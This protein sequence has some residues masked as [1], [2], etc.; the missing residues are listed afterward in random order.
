MWRFSLVVALGLN[1]FGLSMPILRSLT[2]DWTRDSCIGRWILYHWA[3]RK[4]PKFFFLQHSE[5]KD[6]GIRSHHF[7]ANR[8]GKNGNSERLY[9]GGASKSLQMVT[10]AMKTQLA[11]WKKS[12]DQPRQHIKK[13]RC[14]CTD[15]GPSSQSYG[16][17]S[18]PVWMW[19][20]DYKDLMLLNCGIGE[21]SWGSLGQQGYQTNQS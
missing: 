20:L 17:S 2:R 6:H 4:A 8:W 5:N 3:F 16:F 21:D 19:E 13:Q 14:Y 10:A 15:K 18:I 1:S 11:P 9:F 12:Y 7:M